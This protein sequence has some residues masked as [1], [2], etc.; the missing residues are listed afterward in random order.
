MKSKLLKN[1]TSC[2]GRELK[3]LNTNLTPFVLIII[4]LFITGIS[5]LFSGCL[6]I[7]SIKTYEQAK[8]EVEAKGSQVTPPIEIRESYKPG[9]SKVIPK[10]STA[11][12]NGILI[13]KDRATYL[14]AIK[15]E[16]DRRRSELE[17]TLKKAAIDKLIYDST[18][19]N[20]K[21]RAN[22]MKWWHDNKGWI[23][24]V[25]GGTLIG[26]LVVGIVYALT[27]GKGVNASTN[28]MVLQSIK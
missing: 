18:L 12:Y 3:K 14:A 1:S 23:G 21:A 26:G 25:L 16:R 9:Q 6:K 10:D 27:N 7:P 11:P 15:A 17:T 5:L 19:E 22:Y 8:K 20:I 13:D 24:F 4:G 2:W 28:T